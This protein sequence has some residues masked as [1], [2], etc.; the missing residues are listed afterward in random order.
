MNKSLKLALYTVIAAVAL[1]LCSPKMRAI[2]S[3]E[4]SYI[5]NMLAV[6]GPLYVFAPKVST[7]PQGIIISSN[8]Y[9]GSS[10]LGVP[11]I[12]NGTNFTF[13]GSYTTAGRNALTP[14]EGMVIYDTTVHMFGFYNG[15]NWVTAGGTAGACAPTADG[16]VTAPGCWT[17]Y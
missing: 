7:F 4:G 5:Y 8:A 15:T 12:T 13:V 1:L 11:T 2:A 9:N 16:P 6:R 3:V 17:Y 14:T 10:S